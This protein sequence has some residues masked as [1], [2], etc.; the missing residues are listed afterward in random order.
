MAD[1]ALM[2]L[3]KDDAM[4]WPEKLAALVAFD[5][6]PIARSRE[7][8][9]PVNP[10]HDLPEAIAPD[11]F[12]EVSISARVAGL[13]TTEQYGEIIDGL[14]AKAPAAEPAAEPAA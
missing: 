11:S 12:D 13:I 5:Y 6:Q 1:S 3:L 8:G 2:T 9:E 10:N 4:D 14:Q 7:P